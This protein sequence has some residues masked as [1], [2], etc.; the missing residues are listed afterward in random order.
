MSNADELRALGAKLASN[1]DSV[2]DLTPE[3]AIEVRKHLN[4]LG[5]VISDKKSYANISLINWTSESMKK[6]YTTGLI[7]Y[8][9]RTLEEYEPEEEIERAERDLKKRLETSDVADHDNIKREHAEYVKKLTDTARGIVRRFL[10]R[11]FRF[12]PDHHL[13][14]AHSEN[15]KD[16]ERMP[17][18]EAIRKA[19]DTGV[20]STSVEAKLNRD[21]PKTYE[22]LR[23]NMLATYQAAVEATTTL[24][25]VLT[26]LLDPKISAD[27]KQG[28]LLKRYRQLDALC[29]DMKKIAEP[30]QAADTLS[31]WKV[32]PPVDVFHQFNRY[33]TNHYEQLRAVC[34]A[35]YNEKPDMEYAIIYYNSFKTEDAAREHRVQHEAEFRTEVLTIE[36]SGVTLV[37]PSKEN[38][39]RVDFY[40]K[41]T[42]VMK[43]MMEQMETD[44][45]L[46]KDLMEKQVKKKKKQNIA[47]SG[48]DAPGLASYSKA[49]GTLQ[50]L[51][52]KQVLTREEK[53]KLAAA[54]AEKEDAEVPDDAIQV[55]MFFPT[56]ENGQQVMK[57]TK[58][59]TQAEAPLHLQEGS[60]Y[61]EQYQPKRDEEESLTEAYRK[62]TIVDRNG[63]KHELMVPAEK[64]S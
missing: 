30:L 39:G 49:V 15:S 26:T 53:D 17:K 40:N 48:P 23:S 28:I 16:P 58:F 8:V 62:K 19:C 51:G 46:G 22:Y 5:N 9:Y 11:N 2:Y 21:L 4:P 56:E 14:A 25:A 44:H 1:P 63:K 3:Q 47:E 7:G 38:R 34:S 57:K 33:L 6:L 59:Y 18:D 35:L 41:N 29:L 32:D 50:E 27:D 43:R 52:A 45:K 37:G 61:H 54:I 13:R 55:D 31:A 60:Q 36:N 20:K 10:N 12:N 42:E 64:S 24:K